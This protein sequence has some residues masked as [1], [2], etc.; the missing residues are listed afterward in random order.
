VKGMRSFQKE[1]D[2]PK[3]NL[4][5]ELVGGNALVVAISYDYAII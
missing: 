2:L 5:N 3:N 1:A 4:I